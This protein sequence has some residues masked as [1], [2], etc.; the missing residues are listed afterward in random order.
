MQ[1]SVNPA[2]SAKPPWGLT[3]RCPSVIASKTCFV[4]AHGR[5]RSCGLTRSSWCG[6]RTLRGSVCGGW[7]AG[8]MHC[9][10]RIGACVGSLWQ[11]VCNLATTEA[12]RGPG[13]QNQLLDEMKVELEEFPGRRV[14]TDVEREGA[15]LEYADHPPAALRAAAEE[16]DR[17]SALIPTVPQSALLPPSLPE[18]DFESQRS[19]QEPLP[20]VIQAVTAATSQGLRDRSRSPP[21]DAVSRETAEQAWRAHALIALI[22]PSGVKGASALLRRSPPT[23]DNRATRHGNASLN[24]FPAQRP[25]LECPA[26]AI[27]WS[28]ADEPGHWAPVTVLEVE[29]DMWIE[30]DRGVVAVA[31]WRS[32]LGK[33]RAASQCLPGG[34]EWALWQYSW[35]H[36]GTIE[37]QPD[38]VHWFDGDQ[39]DSER[40]ASSASDY[41]FGVVPLPAS[42][43][44]GMDRHSGHFRGMRRPRNSPVVSRVLRRLCR[45]FSSQTAWRGWG[46]H[47]V[48]QFSA[49][50]KALRCAT[51]LL[52]LSLL[53]EY[54]L[55]PWMNWSTHEHDSRHEGWSPTLP[56]S[57]FVVNPVRAGH[58]LRSVALF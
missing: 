28:K 45:A 9:V 42:H 27:R 3:P 43:G 1:A 35:Q 56:R 46:L 19:F 21:Q 7:D 44:G 55:P 48:S 33:L 18:V 16:E 51:V 24:E 53:A 10:W 49:N 52:W 54:A 57:P 47:L 36:H 34:V 12:P 4:L 37:F 38:N 15:P 14:C 8:V 31:G 2:K 11:P 23:R 32:H 5:R 58:S 41:R 29:E 25:R 50:G 26:S 22:E 17:A 40:R 39:D 13:I 20:P 30:A 6:R